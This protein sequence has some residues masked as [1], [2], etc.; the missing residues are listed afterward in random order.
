[1]DQQ[2][3]LKLELKSI[4]HDIKNLS[5]ILSLLSDQSK[6]DFSNINSL[7]EESDLFLRNKDLPADLEKISSRVSYLA[8][9]IYLAARDEIESAKRDE[10]KLIPTEILKRVIR[11]VNANENSA[12]HKVNIN[13]KGSSKIAVKAIEADLEQAFMNILFNSIDL[14]PEGGELEIEISETQNKNQ[15]RCL[16]VVF[17]DQGPGVNEKQ[18]KDLFKPEISLRKNQSSGMGLFLIRGII[19]EANGS[20]R[21]YNSEKEGFGAEFEI[22]LPALVEYEFY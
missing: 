14:M 17:R 11:W 12:L 16:K 6:K 22:I 19:T 2:Q 5:L 4:A 13:K 3:T 9:R 20:L 10:V 21:L 8:K 15:E 18:I 7:I 1:M